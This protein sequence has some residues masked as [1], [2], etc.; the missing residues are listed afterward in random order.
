MLTLA[1]RRRVCR[2]GLGLGRH[3]HRAG[4]HGGRH[5]GGG[6]AAITP[7]SFHAARTHPR[8]PPRPPAMPS[9]CIINVLRVTKEGE[10]Q[11]KEAVVSN[12]D[13]DTVVICGGEKL[14]NAQIVKIRGANG[15][16]Y[17]VVLWD[18]GKCQDGDDDTHFHPI[19]RYLVPRPGCEWPYDCPVAGNVC[20]S[21]LG[22][23]ISNGETDSEGEDPYE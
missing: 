22:R 3:N 8:P 4:T 19:Y 23:N 13:Y 9:S 10:L 2:A 15:I 5:E 20:A 17:E 18:D 7:P 12:Q 1:Y 11:V 6:A 16:M 14:P 21:G